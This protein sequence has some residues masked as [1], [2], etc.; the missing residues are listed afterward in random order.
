MHFSGPSFLPVDA[1]VSHHGLPGR[2]LFL[3]Y[4]G[5]WKGKQ[6]SKTSESFRW[7][8][9]GKKWEFV[10]LCSICQIQTNCVRTGL[11]SLNA[12]DTITFFHSI[13]LVIYLFE[14]RTILDNIL[15]LIAIK[16]W[17]SEV[18]SGRPKELLTLLG[19]ALM[20][21][22]LLEEFQTWVV[23]YSFLESTWYILD[24]LDWVQSQVV[25]NKWVCS[26]IC[27]LKL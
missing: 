25:Q 7:K 24:S 10:P 5:S 6:G 15:G 13:G 3:I 11:Y 18:C 22:L 1:S 8:V 14:D 17:L 23:Q 19:T 9:L 26:Q 27:V 20:L 2:Q 21:K 16:Q 4:T 12:E